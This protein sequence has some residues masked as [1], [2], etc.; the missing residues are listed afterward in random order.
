MTWA[1]VGGPGQMVRHHARP[2][3]RRPR[4][5]LRW[6]LRVAPAVAAAGR[7]VA[8]AVLAVV[9]TLGVLDVLV[10]AWALLFGGWG[11]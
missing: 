9:L 6:G 1:Q 5:R 3:P 2:R 8:V 10:I 11:L 7:V 4:W